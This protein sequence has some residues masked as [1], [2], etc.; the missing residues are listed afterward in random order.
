MGVGEGAG[1]RVGAGV[2]VGVGVSVG[3]GVAVA[4]GV[5]EGVGVSAGVDVPFGVGV[6]G[7]AVA[8][9]KEGVFVAEGELPPPPLLKGCGYI[10]SP[11]Y[12][13]PLTSA[14]RMLFTISGVEPFGL[15]MPRS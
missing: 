14:V 4:T 12:G 3:V 13:V 7:G 11:V 8:D 6:G 1:G 10:K 15:P 2:A 5:G 9:G